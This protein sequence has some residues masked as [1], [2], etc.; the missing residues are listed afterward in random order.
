MNNQTFM[1]AGIILCSLG[2][3]YVV[4]TKYLAVK[5]MIKDP[6]DDLSHVP[7]MGPP[8]MGHMPYAVPPNMLQPELL[9]MPQDEA[10]SMGPAPAIPLTTAAEKRDICNQTCMLHL[11]GFGIISG[12]PF[13]NVILPTLFWL[14]KKEQHPFLAKQGREVIN[15]HITYTLIQFFCLGVGILFIR[16]MPSSAAKLFAF[17]KVVRIVF[18]SGMYLPFNVF[19]ILPFFWACIVMIRGAVAAYHGVSYKYPAAQQ[20]LFANNAGAKPQNPIPANAAQAPDTQ[21]APGPAA[22]NRM[23]FG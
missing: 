2:G 20:F 5:Q 6:D 8:P 23:S 15:F 11:L 10:A 4:L 21:Q 17:T 18:S 9:G 16:F 14:W 12:I 19:T 13:L 7:G 3:W 1:L 22:N